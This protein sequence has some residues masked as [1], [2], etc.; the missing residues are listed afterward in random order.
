MVLERDEY[1]RLFK[2]VDL[3]GGNQITREELEQ[4]LYPVN[5]LK[6]TLVV[7]PEMKRNDREGG[8]DGGDDGGGDGDGRGSP[9]RASPERADAGDDSDD[10]ELGEIK[11]DVA[12][13]DEL[14]LETAQHTI[15]RV[16]GDL[17]YD[18]SAGSSKGR[19]HNAEVRYVR[20]QRIAK[21]LGKDPDYV[22][23]LRRD[24]LHEIRGKGLNVVLDN[25]YR[26]M[27][28]QQVKSFIVRKMDKMLALA[29]VHWIS[30]SGYVYVVER[31]T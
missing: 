1:M 9:G 29:W 18:A 17:Q 15:D 21:A 5:R 14:G 28:V 10:S 31:G 13:V 22:R 26:K 27:A 25:C 6:R 24:L 19:T 2:A 20:R 12:G 16:T 4:A 3:D 7:S 11:R 8:D 23:R 30:N